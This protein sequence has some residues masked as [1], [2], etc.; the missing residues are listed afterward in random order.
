MSSVLHC[1]EMHGRGIRG[2]VQRAAGCMSKGCKV[3]RCRSKRFKAAGCMAE[4]FMATGYKQ[5]NE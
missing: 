4:G 1:N 5:G 3:A 2:D